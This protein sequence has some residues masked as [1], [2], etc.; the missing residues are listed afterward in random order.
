MWLEASVDVGDRSHILIPYL[1][2]DESAEE[3]EFC[4]TLYS[5]MPP[6]TDRRSTA[7]AA[8]PQ[9]QGELCFCD[10]CNGRKSPFQLVIEKMEQVEQIMDER[11]GFLD[12]LIAGV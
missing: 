11:I 6:L 12:R 9:S 2:H 8:K 4:L 10:K 7:P 3:L 5:D 1:S